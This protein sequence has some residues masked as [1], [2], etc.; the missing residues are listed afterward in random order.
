MLAEILSAMEPSAGDVF[1]DC[2]FGR[3]GHTREILNRIGERGRVLAL[4][5]DPQAVAAGR[6]LAQGEPR[7]TLEHTAFSQLAGRAEANQ[8][9]SKVKG[10][11]FDLGVSSPQLGDPTRGFSFRENGPL[12]MRMDPS[13]GPT[14]AEWLNRATGSDIERVLRRFGEEPRARRVARALIRARVENAITTTG[15]LAEIVTRAI[16]PARRTSPRAKKH[17]ATRVFQALRIQTNQELEELESAL[18]QA[19]AILRPGGRLAVISFHSL[20]DRIVKRFIRDHQRGLRHPR[21]LPI[22]STEAGPAVPRLRAIGRVRRASAG[23]V[24][25]N[26]R[27]RSAVLR[28]AEKG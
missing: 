4:D 15:E 23:E 20:E 24:A 2:T 26:P 18:D 25:G 3:G 8:I 7:L 9:I 21:R 12:D 6:T 10:V 19:L 11:L 13:R 27:A 16:P 1:V 17:P 28:V 14:A 5:R 22:K